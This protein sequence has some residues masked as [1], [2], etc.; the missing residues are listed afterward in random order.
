MVLASSHV[1]FVRTSRRGDRCLSGSRS[2]ATRFRRLRLESR[3]L[4][5]RHAQRCHLFRYTNCRK[6]EQPRSR[7]LR[8]C[9]P[10]A[11]CL[12]L[13]PKTRDA[14]SRWDVSKGGRGS[15]HSHAPLPRPLVPI[16]TRL[17]RNLVRTSSMPFASFPCRIHRRWHAASVSADG[18][19]SRRLLSR[20]RSAVAAA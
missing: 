3:R 17:H 1:P 16:P 15:R 9:S 10:M 4:H 13:L 7:R 2:L 11:C 6:R 20:A 12:T 5:D 8:G 19:A 14:I 18:T